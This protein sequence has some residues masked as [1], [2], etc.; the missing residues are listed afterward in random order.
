MTNNLQHKGLKVLG[1]ALLGLSLN[2]SAQLE[3]TRKDLPFTGTSSRYS[4][5]TGVVLPA[6]FMASGAN[7]VWD[8]SSLKS[9]TTFTSKFLV[10]TQDNGGTEI[11]GCNMVFQQDDQFEDYSF[12]KIND[13][14]MT[15]IGAAS[16]GA[17]PIEG[18]DLN[19]RLLVFPLKLNTSWKDSGAVNSVLPGAAL[20]FPFDSVKLAV[21]LVSNSSCDAEGKLRLP[22][23]EKDVLRVKTETNYDFDIQIFNPLTGWIPLTSEKGT[24]VNYSFFAQNGGFY[25]AQISIDEDNAALGFVDYR[26]ETLTNITST[27]KSAELSLFPNPYTKGLLQTSLGNDFAIQ[28]FG[29]DGKAHLTAENLS[30][31]AT[32]NAIEALPAGTYFIKLNNQAGQVFNTRFVKQ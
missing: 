11:D 12:M 15:A 4:S 30:S 8:F 28:I 26:D 13:T 14:E 10:P 22:L 23:G 2:A 17:L 27:Q 16:D 25:L 1:I 5:D 3:I 6:N 20:G 31:Q 9:T 24:E 18:L 19:L 7:K 32:Q 29:M 21:K